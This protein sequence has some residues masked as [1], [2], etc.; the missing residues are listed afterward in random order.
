MVVLQ[1]CSVIVEERHLGPGEGG[2]GGGVNDFRSEKRGKKSLCGVEG[3]K[4]C[5]IRDLWTLR[6]NID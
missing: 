5:V 6:K 3:G 4:W 2:G 1:D